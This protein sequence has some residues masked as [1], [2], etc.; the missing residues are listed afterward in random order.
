LKRAPKKFF[1]EMLA[2][3]GGEE[4]FSRHTIPKLQVFDQIFKNLTPLFRPHTNLAS[5]QGGI[6]LAF[7]L[8]SS[9][10]F[11]A[12]SMATASFSAFSNVKAVF[13]SSHEAFRSSL[14][15]LASN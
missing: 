13:Q 2:T 9:E 11:M 1:P 4:K 3:G 14:R 12:V 10:S 7:P 8:N 15:V 5:V 6:V